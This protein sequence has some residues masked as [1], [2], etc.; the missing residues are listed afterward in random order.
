MMVTLFFTALNTVLYIIPSKIYF[1]PLRIK[2]S[3][4]SIEH[5]FQ[6]VITWF[7]LSCLL[8]YILL[9]IILLVLDW[10]IDTSVDY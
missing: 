4:A 8:L 5:L 3:P 2:N 1:C 9:Y 10:W 6:I 7:A